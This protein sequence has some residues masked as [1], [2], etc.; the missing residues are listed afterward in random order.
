[1]HIDQLLTFNVGDSGYG[2]LVLVVLEGLDAQFS[3]CRIVAI[4]CQATSVDIVFTYGE[5]AIF[6]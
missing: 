6:F 2:A 3:M 5:H 1:L 4:N